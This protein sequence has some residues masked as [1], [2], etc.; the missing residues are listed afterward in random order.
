M[1]VSEVNNVNSLR[2]ASGSGEHLERHNTFLS[3]SSARKVSGNDH[4]SGGG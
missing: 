4:I 2:P 1:N 3:F